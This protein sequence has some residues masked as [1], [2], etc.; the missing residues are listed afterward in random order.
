MNL[1]YEENQPF[2]YKLIWLVWHPETAIVSPGHTETRIYGANTMLEICN[3]RKALLA[4]KEM[5]QGIQ[6]DEGRWL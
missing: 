1:D 6:D 5:V 3:K 2:K 4:N